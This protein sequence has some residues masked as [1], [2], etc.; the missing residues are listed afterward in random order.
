MCNKQHK[1]TATIVDKRGR[2]L[3][4]G[5]NNYTK[6]HPKQTEY[7]ELAGLPQK[8]YLHA[9]VAAII[10]CKQ[11]I[12]KAHAIHIERYDSKGNPKLAAPCPVCVL[13]I[14]QAGIKH[15]SFTVG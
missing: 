14:Q 13:A 12:N 6:T 4:V 11:R 15:V 2:T 3:A 5:Y 10:K 1:L 8:E 7:A 9:E